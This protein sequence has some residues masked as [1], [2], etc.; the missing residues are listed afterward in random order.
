MHQ[1]EQLDPGLLFGRV[2]ILVALYDVD[3]DRQPFVV[4]RKGPVAL[5]NIRVTLRTQV[6]HRR[7]I[8]D[9]QG[10]FVA[11]YEW[12][13]PFYIGADRVSHARVEPVVDMGK[14]KVQVGLLCSNGFHLGY[15]LGLHFPRQ[16][17]S[18]IKK[19][20]ARGIVLSCSE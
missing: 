16:L 14:H 5:G 3:V 6:P 7:G 15:P 13:H 1:L 9:E 12:H 4:R 18:E 10:H 19:S 8:L 17:P 11:V 2:D 20:A